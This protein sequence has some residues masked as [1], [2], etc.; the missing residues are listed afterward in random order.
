MRLLNWTPTKSI[1]ERR[2]SGNLRPSPSLRNVR[3]EYER[4]QSQTGNNIMARPM[5]Y[6]YLW[7]NVE[8]ISLEE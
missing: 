7:K 3:D 2:I 6:A 8:P 5:K 1:L 4:V